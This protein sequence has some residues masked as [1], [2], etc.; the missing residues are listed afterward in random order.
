MKMF[1]GVNKEALQIP[2]LF[3]NLKSTTGANKFKWI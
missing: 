3:V 1:V 2:W